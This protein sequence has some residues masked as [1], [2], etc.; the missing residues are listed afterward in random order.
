MPLLLFGC[1]KKDSKK[2]E[3]GGGRGKNSGGRDSGPIAV[4]VEQA[5]FSVAPRSINVVATLEGRNQA[6]VYSKV[7]GR[8]SY[9]GPKEGEPVKVGTLLFRV[10]RSDPGESFLN[11][12]V[13]SPISG[14]IGRWMV[15]NI[16]AQVTATTP[17]VTVV[18]DEF[19]RAT[20]YLSTNEW[21]TIDEKAR[22]TVTVGE[23]T[24]PGRVVSIARAA[25]AISGRGSAV[26]EVENKGHKWRAGMIARIT[27]DL[28]PKNRMLISSAAV[29][30]TDQG[31]YVFVVVDGVAHKKPI[32]FALVDSDT[33]EILEG[34][35]D[36]SYVVVAGGNYLTDKAPAKIVG[37]AAEEAPKEEK[38]KKG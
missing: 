20:V 12:P 15:N 21:V 22:V 11:T 2:G 5:K 13:I 6:D 35:E 19:L 8:L 24:K 26:V 30:I 29:S 34:I 3:H 17:V 28:E 16:G 7:T 27:V 1:S 32:K 31:P 25:D 4:R 38:A 18:D 33:L 9:I 14:W 37:E 23:E 36:N 10:D